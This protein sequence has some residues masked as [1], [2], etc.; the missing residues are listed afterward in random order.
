MK[1]KRFSHWFIL[2][3][4]VQSQT[5]DIQSNS[6]RT[7]NLTG[8]P[9]CLDCRRRCPQENLKWRESQLFQSTEIAW[10]SEKFEIE[11]KRFYLSVFAA[12]DKFHPQLIWKLDKDGHCTS[13]PGHGRFLTCSCSS[14]MMAVSLTPR[15]VPWIAVARQKTCW[16]LA[17]EMRRKTRTWWG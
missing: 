11:K 7:S 13:G 4:P 5:H 14:W 17:I 1:Q 12:V 8:K 15:D 6:I 10:N 3:Q 2:N 16:L 9:A